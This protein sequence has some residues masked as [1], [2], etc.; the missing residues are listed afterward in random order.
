[1]KLLKMCGKGREKNNPF[2]LFRRD[3]FDASDEKLK[4]SGRV[5]LALDSFSIWQFVYVGQN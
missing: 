5:V 3:H 1:M 4:E 2:T